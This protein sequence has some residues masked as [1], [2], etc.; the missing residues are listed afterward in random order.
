MHNGCVI[1]RLGGHF[2]TMARALCTGA[3]KDRIKRVAQYTASVK[4]T[5]D[6]RD[7][8]DAATPWQREQFKTNFLK[9]VQAPQKLSID[10]MQ[11]KL[12]GTTSAIVTTSKN[13]KSDSGSKKQKTKISPPTSAPVPATAAPATTLATSSGSHPLQRKPA[14][15]DKP[16]ESRRLNDRNSLSSSSSS[17]SS[18]SVAP[19]SLISGLDAHTMQIQN[20]LHIEDHTRTMQVCACICMFIRYSKYSLFLY[21]HYE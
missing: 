2:D 11:E 5:A 10:G 7:A 4:F 19:S 14:V 17:S 13:S 8:F 1:A 18:N 15:Q 20:M 16:N 12:W 21:L 3:T 9:L 6:Q